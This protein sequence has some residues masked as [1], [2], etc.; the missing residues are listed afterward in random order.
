MLIFAIS[1]TVLLLCA[2]V[3]LLWAFNRAQYFARALADK[4]KEFVES[5]GAEIR[6]TLNSCMNTLCTKDS[7]AASWGEMCK[8]VHCRR[9]QFLQLEQV[10]LFR[11]IRY[12]GGEEDFI[13]VHDHSEP[14]IYEK[15]KTDPASLQPF[16]GQ[17]CVMEA[18]AVME[19]TY[20]V[21][22]ASPDD[23]R[24]SW[25]EARHVLT[26]VAPDVKANTPAEKEPITYHTIESS[27]SVSEED[28][29]VVFEREIGNL[30][31][32]VADRQIKLIETDARIAVENFF[33]SF[34]LKSFHPELQN[35][36]VKLVADECIPKFSIDVKFTHEA[37][38]LENR[39]GTE[40]GMAEETDPAMTAVA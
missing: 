2:I 9:L 22:L 13:A 7:F 16:L 23:W 15:H 12:R 8:R 37:P 29:K 5:T 35:E 31:Q 6:K 36:V 40:N 30:K 34:I 21:D 4:P 17:Y 20:Y 1:T 10:F 19:V 3:A 32:L 11:H 33:R 28:T 25:D 27:L 38:S 26:I 18:K 14:Y 24:F 39:R